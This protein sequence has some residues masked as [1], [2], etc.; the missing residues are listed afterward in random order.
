MRNDVDPFYQ[1]RQAAERQQGDKRFNLEQAMVERLTNSYNSSTFGPGFEEILAPST[2]KERPRAIAMGYNRSTEV[3]AI[4]FR[5]PTVVNKA[6]KREV[7]T[8]P[9]PMIR[10][11]NIPIDMW[12]DL[13][14]SDSTGKYLRYSGLDNWPDKGP[15]N[16]SDLQRS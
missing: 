1:R 7:I 5:H 11:N 2:N 4:V 9:A 3:L 12:N 8:G 10:Y 15:T 13:K 14:S 6:T 16:K